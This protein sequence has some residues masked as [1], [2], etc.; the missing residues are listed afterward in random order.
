MAKIDPKSRYA[1]VE[2][3]PVVDRR[4]RAVQALSAPPAS[5]E[6]FQGYHLRKQGQ[7]LDHLAYRYLSD[8]AGFWR[9]CEMNDAMV[10][11]SLS[12]A[13]KIA[14]PTK[15]RPKGGK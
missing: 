2:R 13:R 12:E 6:V 4:G 9:I 7:R 5:P 14:I 3:V 15:T 1:G 11:D 8:P 10:P